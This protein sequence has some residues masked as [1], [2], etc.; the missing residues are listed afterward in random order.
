MDNMDIEHI[1]KNASFE[2]L[3]EAT[4]F[5]ENNYIG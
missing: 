1:I 5:R 4:S 3:Q 2:E